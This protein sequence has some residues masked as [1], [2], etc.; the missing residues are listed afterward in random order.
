M[1][2]VRDS[3]LARRAHTRAPRFPPTWPV[4]TPA[5]KLAGWLEYYAEAM[6]L[7]VWTSS[8]VLK[9][10]QDANNE[11]DVSV[12][13]P[14]GSTRV[15]HVRHVVSAIGLG[16][17]TPYFPEIPGKEEYEGQVLHSI[18]HGSAKD[19]IGKKVFIVGSATSGASFNHVVSS[20]CADCC[21]SSRYR[22]G[23]CPPRRW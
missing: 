22:V 15:L 13:R 8:T 5:H 9:A 21:C 16:G 12:Q 19:H 11:W 2:D 4:Y 17:N 6:E 1:L 7:N 3:T 18:F 14:D 20:Q 23:L 10:V